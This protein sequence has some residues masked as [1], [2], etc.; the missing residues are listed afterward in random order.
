MCVYTRTHVCLHTQ[1]YASWIPLELELQ[2][3]WWAV[4][5]GCWEPNSVALEKQHPFLPIELSRQPWLVCLFIC[6]FVV[7][8]IIR[9]KGMTFAHFELCGAAPFASE[10]GGS[11]PNGPWLQLVV[12]RQMTEGARPL[13]SGGARRTK[14]GEEVT[15]IPQTPFRTSVT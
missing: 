6:L 10:F 9:E 8:Y 14:E 3:Q 11:S 2:R 13:T 7:V 4:Q 12:R 15:W 5:H 1:V